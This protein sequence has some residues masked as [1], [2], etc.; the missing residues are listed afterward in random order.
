[1]VDVVVRAPGLLT[2]LCSL[3]VIRL[4]L[5]RVT[6]SYLLA[7]GTT[8][9][10]SRY[11]FGQSRLGL[12]GRWPIRWRPGTRVEWGTQFWPSGFRVY[13]ILTN[14]IWYLFRSSY[15]SGGVFFCALVPGTLARDLPTLIHSRLV[16]FC[17]SM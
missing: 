1:M 3:Y 8:Q 12:C 15:F 5:T 9:I 2:L 7:L 14:S 10:S 16:L 6:K 17:L 4:S 11:K 13:P